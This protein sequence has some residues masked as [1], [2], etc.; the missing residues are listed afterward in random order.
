M[1]TDEAAMEFSSDE[2]DEEVLDIFNTPSLRCL[3]LKKEFLKKARNYKFWGRKGSRQRVIAIDT[4]LKYKLSTLGATAEKTY[5]M[6]GAGWVNEKIYEKMK[7]IHKMLLK[8]VPIP[9]A[10]RD[11]LASVVVAAPRNTF[12]DTLDTTLEELREAALKDYENKELSRMKKFNKESFQL[13]KL[14]KRIYKGVTMIV[15]TTKK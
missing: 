5:K 13:R 1:K 3:Q 12:L 9:K 2:R 4:L 6:D 11:K 15:E 8:E 7:E 14:R 10:V